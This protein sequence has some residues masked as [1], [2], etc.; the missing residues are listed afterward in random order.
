MFE[1]PIPEVGSSSNSQWA[2][3]GGSRPPSLAWLTPHGRRGLSRGG[4]ATGCR[5]PLLERCRLCGRWPT[6]GPHPFISGVPGRT[7]RKKQQ[8]ALFA[9]RRIGA[10]G[11]GRGLGSWEKL[12][13]E[14]AFS[15]RSARRHRPHRPPITPGPCPGP[16]R[17]AGGTGGAGMWCT[18]R[19]RS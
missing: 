3:S 11:P 12:G 5:C 1:E 17:R 14:Y 7:G 15:A 19:I 8:G 10:L 2:G 9:A 16:P 6:F 18:S 4:R 13:L